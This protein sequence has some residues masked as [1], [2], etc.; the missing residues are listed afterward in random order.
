MSTNCTKC[1]QHIPESTPG[2]SMCLPCHVTELNRFMTSPKTVIEQNIQSL[3]DCSPETLH[4]YWT[5]LTELNT[6]VKMFHDAQ[7]R[8]EIQSGNRKKASEQMAET[9]AIRRS[10]SAEVKKEKKAKVQLSKEMEGDAKLVKF[11]LKIK[12]SASAPEIFASM[13]KTNSFD[14]WS[15][16]RVLAVMN[17]AKELL[18]QGK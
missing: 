11:Y 9:E 5:A 3:R 16:E 6:R 1:S 15:V 17:R 10:S 18:S 7:V 2:L 4:G 8:A 13:N 14:D 12:P